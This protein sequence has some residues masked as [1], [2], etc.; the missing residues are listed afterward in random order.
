VPWRVLEP[1]LRADDIVATGDRG[2]TKRALRIEFA[3]DGERCVDCWFHARGVQTGRWRIGQ[4]EFSGRWVHWRE[5]ADGR[6]VRAAS[7]V[8]ARL[9]APQGVVPIAALASE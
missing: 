4:V 7:H 6:I 3:I 9:H 5:A 2:A 8:D 1:V